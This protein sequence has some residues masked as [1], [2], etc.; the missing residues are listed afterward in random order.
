MRQRDEIRDVSV[1]RDNCF[2][3]IRLVLAIVL[4]VSHY[5]TLTGIAQVWPVGGA[6]AVRGF[7]T[8]TGFLVTYSYL[9]HTS[10]RD[11]LILRAGR[12]GPAYLLTIGLCLGIGCAI[13]GVG[14]LR[15]PQTWHYL[16]A[17]VTMLGWLQPCLPGVF[18]GHAIP[19]VNGSLWTMKVEV[20]YYL[21]VPLYVWVARL[22]SRRILTPL[23]ILGVAAT[24]AHLPYQLQCFCYFLGGATV[25]Y[26][27]PWLL[28]HRWST[29]L[30]AIG[31]LA[32]LYSG[33][34]P[35]GV[36]ADYVLLP[37][38]A[39]LMPVAIIGLAYAL[40]CPGWLRRIPDITYGLFLVHFPVIQV[41]IDMGVPA[42]GTPVGIGLTLA[43]SSVLA[44]A[45]WYGIER[46]VMRYCRRIT[47]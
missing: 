6:H 13:G 25:L 34:V 29:L 17:N 11:Y 44:L 30:G 15:H 32:L 28:R 23:T 42:M 36:W 5:C 43:V 22:L 8:L 47:R 38:E 27:R 39:F 2:D 35:D 14:I 26:H 37:A 4:V 9:R 19:A 21:L 16:M 40:P 45:S 46:G 33:I 18:E 7:F 10:L 31:G 24:Y 3:A 12:I 20:G 1:G 41:M